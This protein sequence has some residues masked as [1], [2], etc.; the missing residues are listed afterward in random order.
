MRTTRQRFEH[1]LSILQNNILE[2]AASADDMV[3]RSVKALIEGD[4]ELAEEVVNQ[5]DAVDQFDVDIEQKCLLL[6]VQEQP[7]A[8]DL[9]VVGTA[10]KIISD[11]ERIGDYAV[12]I[13]R[14]AQRLARAGEFYHPLVD[15]PL[16]T[17]LS[18]TMLHDALQAFAQHDLDL[19]AKVIKDDDEVDRVYKAIRD[20]VTRSLS[21][22]PVRGLL[23]L[24]VMFAAKYLERISDH[25][26]NIAERVAFIETNQLKT[27]LF[28]AAGS[29]TSA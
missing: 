24:N 12:D 27:H 25:V 17:H 19:V 8:R 15:L 14:I 2:M 16:L 6:I 28:A 13:A 9:R 26:V 4:A 29:E 21:D 7:V 3:A 23:L 18:R 10:L 22:K 11:I 1:E 5:D 20:Q